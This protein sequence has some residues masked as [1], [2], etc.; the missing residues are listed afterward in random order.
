MFSLSRVGS[1]PVCEVRLNDEAVSRRHAAIDVEGDR[2][3]I[4]DLES[5]NG[6][7][8]N[9]TL[10]LDA[11]LTG[12]ERIVVGATAIAVERSA[13]QGAKLSV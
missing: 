13:Q 9:G 6:T 8:V 12:G 11:Y 1:S 4:T 5:K 2:L 7:R 10:I 3:R